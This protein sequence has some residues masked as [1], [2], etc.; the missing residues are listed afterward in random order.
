MTDVDLG[1][2]LL[3]MKT[4]GWQAVRTT[5]L[6][7]RCDRGAKSDMRPH[8][9]RKRQSSAKRLLAEKSLG[10]R[11]PASRKATTEATPGR[12]GLASVEMTKD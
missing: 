4:V 8:R 9:L 3:M 7:L 2:P 1:H 10:H 6:E 11:P 12:Q 5:N